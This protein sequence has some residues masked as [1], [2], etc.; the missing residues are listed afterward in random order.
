MSQPNRS[1]VHVDRPLTNI[2]IAYMQS[3]N[4][5]I[6]S[7]V[8]PVIPVGKQSDQYFI[9][10]KNDWFRDEAQLRPPDTESAGSGYNLNTESYDAKVWAFHKDV[11]DQ[12]E[13]NSDLPLNPER[14]A[15]QFVASR[16]LLRREIQWATDFF[17]A[18]LG[19]KDYT[20]VSGSPSTDQFKQWSDYAASDPVSDIE[21][22]KAYILGMTG[23]MPNTLVL[24]YEV[25]RHLKQHPDIIDRIKYTTSE[26]VTE[27]YLARLFEVDNV[28]VAK[29]VKATNN[30]GETAA[31]SFVQGKG[32]WLGYVNPTPS[33]LQPSA[34]YTFAWTGVSDGMGA[35]IGTSRIP[36]PLRR[37]TRIES[38]MAWANKIV[39]ADL[40]AF[41]ATAVA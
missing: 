17:G 7:R 35:T 15:A 5:F 33:L 23:F 21:D 8:F 2:S 22:G 4:N 26:N 3:Q 25:Y 40:G 14:D 39:A 30:E 19:W 37:S 27:A 32:A 11:D 16:M 10:T 6:A 38:Q 12:T 18:S 13:N 9:Y 34:G 1:Q 31:Y 29:S 20:G 28:Y 41:F 36:V 24:A